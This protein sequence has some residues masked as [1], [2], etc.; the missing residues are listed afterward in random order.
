MTKKSFAFVALIALLAGMAGSWL[1]GL[2]GHASGAAGNESAYGRVMRTQTMRCGYVVWTPFL[3]KDPNTGQL[4]GIF[5]DYTEALAKA[6]HLKVE[7]TEEMG[8]ADF[9]SAL[10][11][12]RIDVMCGGSWPNSARAREI[13]FVKPILYQQTFAW[14]REGDT[15]FDNNLA[16]I[17][18]PAVRLIFVEGTTQAVIAANDFPNATSVPL[19]ELTSLADTLVSL[20]DGKADVGLVTT[21]A[22]YQFTVN[23]PG[24]VRRIEP[25]TPLRVFGNGLAVAGGEER[26]RRM[27]DV[28]TQEML[29]SGQIDKMIAPYGKVTETWLRPTPPYMKE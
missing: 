7:W 21:E 26:L 18:N 25:A 2:A 16:S 23:N 1:A 9:P 10:N 5:Y 8:W 14:V 4:S 3:L 17:N 12:G 15:R 20:A 24:K 28:A 29:S 6:L 27:L 22:G 11:A 13:D 19:P